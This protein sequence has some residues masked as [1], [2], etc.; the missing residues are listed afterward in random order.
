MP[1]VIVALFTSACMSQTKFVVTVTKPRA[2]FAQPAGPAA[3][4][5]RASS[6]V[7]DV[8]V[9]LF[10]FLSMFSGSYERRGVVLVDR[11]GVFLRQVERLAALPSII[12]TP[13]AARVDASASSSPSRRSKR[14]EQRAAVV[15]AVH[16]QVQLHVLL[17]SPLPPAGTGVV[18]RGT[19]RCG[20]TCRSRLAAPGVRIDRPREQARWSACPCRGWLPPATWA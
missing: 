5:C 18:A 13:S 19:G 14:V 1:S 16:R 15:E 20:R 2:A 17:E 3:A 11:L 4:A 6:G 8:V 10:H 7:V 12:G 9:P